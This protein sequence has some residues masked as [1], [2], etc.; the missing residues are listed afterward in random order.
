VTNALAYFE[1]SL[2]DAHHARAPKVS[3]KAEEPAMNL[4]LKLSTLVTS[5]LIDGARQA[6]G[7]PKVG[8]EVTAIR[9][10]LKERFTDHSQNLIKALRGANERAWRALLRCRAQ[11]SIIPGIA[12]I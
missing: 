4:F 11:R 5:K 2:A 10:F 12:S 8:Q 3:L 6:V 1:V 9:T 7:V